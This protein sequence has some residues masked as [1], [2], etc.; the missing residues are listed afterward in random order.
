MPRFPSRGRPQRGG[1]HRVDIQA[2]TGTRARN[3]NGT[4]THTHTHTHTHTRLAHSDLSVEGRE[5]MPEIPPQEPCGRTADR[6]RVLLTAAWCA[7]PDGP[8]QPSFPSVVFSLWV[9]SIPPRQAR[10]AP[11]HCT[12]SPRNELGWH[13]HLRETFVRPPSCMEVQKML[14]SVLD[15]S[16]ASGLEFVSD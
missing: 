11:A 13:A 10:T 4:R 16:I 2:I 1:L 7:M 5:K 9:A 3:N 14:P 12:R 8:R 15:H 6:A